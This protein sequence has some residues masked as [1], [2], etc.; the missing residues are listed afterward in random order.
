MTVDYTLEGN[1]DA[2]VP[3]N[4]DHMATIQEF[5]GYEHL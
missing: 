4:E 5:G 3:L 2:T 1:D